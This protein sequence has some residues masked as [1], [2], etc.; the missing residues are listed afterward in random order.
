MKNSPSQRGSQ[1]WSTQGPHLFSTQN[2]PVQHQKPLSSTHPSVQ[3]QKPVS[4]TYQKPLSSTPKTE[5]FWYGT[6]GFLVLNWGV[7][8]V[9]L[10]GVLKWRVF[11]VELRDFGC[12]KGVALLWWT[13]V[14]N[15]GWPEWL[16]WWEIKNFNNRLWSTLYRRYSFWSRSSTFF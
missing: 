5:K 1:H 4:S 11:G 3:H 9:E 7:F 13:D 15:W 12:W 8:G 2:L 14:L 6:E 16:E 10:R